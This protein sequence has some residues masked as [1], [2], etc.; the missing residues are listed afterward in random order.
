[1]SAESTKKQPSLYA[2]KL[3]QKISA[4]SPSASTESRQTL[5]NWIVFNRKKA[6]GLS[7]GILLSIGKALEQQDEQSSARILLLLRIVHQV[8]MLNCPLAAGDDNSADIEDKWEKSAQL[9]QKIAESNAVL[10]LKALANSSMG[11]EGQAE[12]DNMMDAWTKYNIFGPTLLDECKKGWTNNVPKDDAADSQEMDA[13][14]PPESTAE[15][16]KSEPDDSAEGPV[17][18]AAS[19][20]LDA[21]GS[22]IGMPVDADKIPEDPVKNTP[23]VAAK[24]DAS[25]EA[26]SEDAAPKRGS[27]ANLGADAEIDYDGV[28]EAKVEPQEFLDAVKVISS[29]QIARDIGS[30]ATM[31][32]SSVLS[33]IPPEVS[34]ACSKILDQKSKGE[35]Q[36][37]VQDAISGDVLANLPSELLDMD[38]KRARQTIQSYREAIR[39]QRR[40]RL[41]CLHLLMQSRCS[42]GSLDAARAFCGGED[43]GEVDM[44]SVLRKLDSRRVALTDAMA[45]EGLDVE[46]DDAEEERRMERDLKLP[47]WFPGQGG[48]GTEGMGMEQPAAKK[49]KFENI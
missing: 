39:Q 5:A 20:K 9:R 33:G 24:A 25:S 35:A 12:V 31:S 3:L 1:M 27:F 11:S 2:R 7:E 38:L 29:I 41:H 15:S 8:F 34:V 22:S 10:L 30:D 49:A 40:A 17:E 47:T 21:E 45:L 48:Q 19:S 23:T 44:N 14:K 16:A 13:D 46:E 32:I 42:F 6:D 37:P 18:L 28:D 26:A 43:G 4:L 36:T